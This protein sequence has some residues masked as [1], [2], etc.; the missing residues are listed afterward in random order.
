MFIKIDNLIIYNISQIVLVI[1]Q[2]IPLIF[3]VL[4]IL[5]FIPINIIKSYGGFIR[6]IGSNSFLILYTKSDLSN[7][8]L[9]INN[10]LYNFK[11]IEKLNDRYI[12]KVNLENEINYNNNV[13]LVNI[14]SKKSIFNILIRK[15]E[16]LK[17]EKFN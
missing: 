9:Y 16:K 10:N 8:Q 4:L 7:K 1:T 12:L 2:Y 11:I 13:L 3:I 17:Y 14:L 6:K 5:S 15:G